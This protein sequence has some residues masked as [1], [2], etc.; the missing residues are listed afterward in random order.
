VLET[1]DISYDSFGRKVKATFVTGT[2]THSVTQFSYDSNGRL[3]CSAV[4]M[5]PAEFAS[6]PTSAC[7]PDTASASF[8]PDRI[9]KTSY[10]AA[11]Q[12]TQVATLISG[13]FQPTAT[14][15]YTTNGKVQ[16]LTDGE[17]NKTTFEYDGHDRPLKTRLPSPTKGAG[18]SSTTDYEQLTYESVASG[19]RTS[20]LVV[21]RRLRDGQ[22]IGFGFD[23]LARVTTKNLPGTEPDVT[24]GYDNLG[25]ATSVSRTGHALSFTW[26]A[27]GRQQTATGPLGTVDYDYDA[28]GRR[29]R[30]TYPGSGLY[31]DYDYLV[32]GE[33]TKVRENGATTGVGVLGTYAYNDLGQRTSLTRGNGTVTSYTF[34]TASRQ[35]P[36]LLPDPGPV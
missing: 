12:V 22:S 26:D 33:V 1:A 10:D 17:N 15:T 8:G 35:G 29:T 2:T 4:R 14:S 25:R 11:D 18:T 28:A 20:G 23:N 31:V 3:D 34:D 24:Y 36:H 19:T 9:G 13:V 21:S 16:T 27:L 6:L 5:N 7:T 30:T 32:T